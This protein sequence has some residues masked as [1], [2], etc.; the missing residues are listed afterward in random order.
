MAAYRLV[1]PPARHYES[2]RGLVLRFAKLNGFASMKSLATLVTQRTSLNVS[3]STDIAQS[4]EAL[5]A[6]ADMSGLKGDDFES[7]AWARHPSADEDHLRFQEVILPSDAVLMDRLQVCPSCVA[8]EAY[9]KADWDLSHVVACPEHGCLLT[10][11][12]AFCGNAISTE[13]AFTGYCAECGA[14]FGHV[15][16]PLASASTLA[17]SEDA[18][19]LAPIAFTS[20]TH[21]HVAHSA[22]FFEL[23]RFLACSLTDVWTNKV[24]KVMFA[25]LSVSDRAKVLDEVG[26]YRVGTGYSVERLRSGLEMRFEHLAP[27]DAFGARSMRVAQLLR[28]SRLTPDLRNFVLHGDERGNPTS[29][30]AFLEGRTSGYTTPREVARLLGI[31]PEGVA[32]L[33]RHG[34]LN[35]PL[36]ELGYSTYEI[37]ACHDVLKSLVPCHRFDAALG[38]TGLAAELAQHGLVELWTLTPQHPPGL[39]LSSVIGLLDALRIATCR[40]VV[41]GDT[42][43]R[44]EFSESDRRP[45]LAPHVYGRLVVAL[46]NGTVSA[47]GWRAPWRLQ[48]IGIAERAMSSLAL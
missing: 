15:D 13:R 1:W 40:F 5:R 35:D 2:V 18:A 46:L 34:K 47:S 37:L 38:V 20:G 33:K 10:D 25:H 16:A 42:G 48:D 6:L 43:R 8:K 4:P 41:D 12:C 44:L 27:F 14:A 36:D 24:R 22:S 11:A 26:S 39:T 19:G 28:S 9:I 29:S 17:A 23:C 32:W 3:S 21:R 45:T 30:A 31:T 7:M